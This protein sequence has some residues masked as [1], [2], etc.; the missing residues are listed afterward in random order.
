MGWV[1]LLLL[2]SNPI[3]LFQSER[4]T[5]L[6]FWKWKTK[7]NGSDGDD[8]LGSS[9][10]ILSFPLIPTWWALCFMSSLQ[11]RSWWR[12]CPCRYR[13]SAH[14]VVPQRLKLP[15]RAFVSFFV[16][17]AGCVTWSECVL[18]HLIVA[19]HAEENE[20]FFPPSLFSSNW[21]AFLQ[22][23]VFGFSVSLC[24]FALRSFVFDREFDCCAI[25]HFVSRSIISNSALNQYSVLLNATA[26]TAA[27]IHL[28]ATVANN[29][30]GCIIGREL[31]HAVV[32]HNWKLTRIKRSFVRGNIHTH[33]HMVQLG[34][35]RWVFV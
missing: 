35:E 3:V 23:F 16:V 17:V 26:A 6:M 27:T 2:S 5:V 31:N 34:R 12:W 14:A 21:P 19:W 13:W 30:S 18:N 1:F 25:V 15:P 33:T 22:D 7:W 24:P 8:A 28:M 4:A 20:I 10:S 11:C 32:F 29:R 9:V